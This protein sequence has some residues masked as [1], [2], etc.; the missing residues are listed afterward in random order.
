M[1][2]S[3]CLVY[4]RWTEEHKSKRLHENSPTNFQDTELFLSQHLK[5]SVSNCY[6]V[7]FNNQLLDR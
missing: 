4:Y 5:V 2:C 3:S 7:K 1:S 6:I